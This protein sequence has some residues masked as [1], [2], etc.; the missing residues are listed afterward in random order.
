MYITAVYVI[1]LIKFRLPKAK[2]LYET[3]YSFKSLRT[4]KLKFSF[5]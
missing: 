4:V 5:I 1:F 3:L 2:N